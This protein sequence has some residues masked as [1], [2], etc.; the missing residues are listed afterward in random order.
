MVF[1]FCFADLIVRIL[2]GPEFLEPANVLRIAVCGFIFGNVSYPA[3]LQILIPHRLARQ[4][5]Y[6]MRIAGLINLPV[7]GLLAWQFGAIG[8]ACSLVLAEYLVFCGIVW[9]MVKNGIFAAYRVRNHAALLDASRGKNLIK[10]CEQ[11]SVQPDEIH[12]L[13]GQIKAEGVTLPV[14]AQAIPRGRFFILH[15]YWQQGCARV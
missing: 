2:L 10:W 3:G 11:R 6:M 7:C 4:R 5:M 15:T 13:F 8:A 1:A 9:L 12:F 14:T